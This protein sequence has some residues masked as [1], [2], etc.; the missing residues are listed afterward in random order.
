[1]AEESLPGSSAR[2]RTR[3]SSSR[4]RSIR[5]LN[6]RPRDPIPGPLADQRHEHRLGRRDD[7]GRMGR[8]RPFHRLC[9]HHDPSWHGQRHLDR[10]PERD[11]FDAQAV[12]LRAVHLSN[13]HRF[14]EDLDRSAL[15]TPLS[16]FRLP[17]TPIRLLGRHRRAGRVLPRLRHLLRRRVQTHRKL[18]LPREMS[19]GS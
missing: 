8:H 18:P 5:H 4:H 17:A 13:H 16:G 10:R 9:R 6:H 15:S 2:L 12:L 14:D 7:S 3:E 1:M 11:H 19:E